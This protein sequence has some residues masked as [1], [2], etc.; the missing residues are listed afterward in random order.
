MKILFTVLS[1]S[2]ER[3]VYG[4]ADDLW[5]RSLS[6]E[7]MQ[8][9]ML[10]FT[11]AFRSQPVS[12]P[13]EHVHV[14]LKKYSIPRFMEDAYYRALR[15]KSID[16][17]DVIRINMIDT[18]NVKV[19][20]LLRWSI[21]YLYMCERLLEDCEIRAVVLLLGRGLFQRCLGFMARS[22]A[23]NTFYL[24]DGFIPGKTL[25]LWKSEDQV[26][27]DLKRIPLPVLTP[28]QKQE[29]DEF[30]QEQTK[31]KNIAASPYD[32]TSLH[33]KIRSFFHLLF[34]NENLVGN[35]NAVEFTIYEILRIFRRFMARHYY[36]HLTGD[37]YLFLPFQVYYD[38]HLPLFWAEYQNLEYYVDVCRR[39][40]P[41]GYK[42]VVKEHPHLRGGVPVS[43]LRRISRMTD[44]VLVDVDVNSQELVQ[45]CDAVVTCCSSIGWQAMMHHKPVVALISRSHPLY[46][47]YYTDYG[48]TLNMDEDDLTWGFQQAIRTSAMPDRVDS[49][50]FHVILARY[51][52]TG[53]LCPVEYTQMEKDGNIH[54]VSEYLYKKMR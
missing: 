26:T 36:H 14:L 53:S 16:L 31:V 34:H 24:C 21:R 52:G 50:L 6:E 11:E 41:P 32:A 43:V 5:R 54:I 39:N 40:L 37:P 44:V 25:H 33:R 13:E 51:K 15:Y 10:W 30:I 48:I 1:G 7:E 9:V 28:A 23:I 29:L 19:E 8:P 38:F 27:E 3:M 42:L 22:M 35:K 17:M 2:Y 4:L 45:G 49:F 20:K 46:R 12:Y 47:Y 18:P